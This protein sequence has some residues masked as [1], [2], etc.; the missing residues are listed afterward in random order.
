VWQCTPIIPELWR[1][2][3]KA[4]KGYTAQLC[5]KKDKN[6]HTKTKTKQGSNHNKR[7]KTIQK[8]NIYCALTACQAL[9]KLLYSFI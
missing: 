8:P 9:A 7:Q 6:K 3:F 2:E 5:L 4:S 1:L